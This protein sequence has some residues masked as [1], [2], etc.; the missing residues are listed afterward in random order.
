MKL[1]EHELLKRL[2]ND[3]SDLDF[4]VHESATK[5]T[6]AVVYFYEGDDMFKQLEEVSDE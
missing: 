1:T 6:V 2:D 4:S 5:G 3:F